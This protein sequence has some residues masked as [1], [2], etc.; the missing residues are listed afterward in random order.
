MAQT[1]AN[2]AVNGKLAI[3]HYVHGKEAKVWAFTDDNKRIYTGKKVQNGATVTTFDTKKVAGKTY[4]R[5]NGAN[6]NTWISSELLK[7]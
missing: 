5:I 1:A 7:K 6:S 2:N 4:I 3:I